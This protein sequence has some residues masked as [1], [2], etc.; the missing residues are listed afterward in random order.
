MTA[1]TVSTNT[2]FTVVQGDEHII[3]AGELAISNGDTVKLTTISAKGQVYD[4]GVLVPLN[5][6]FPSADI[7]SGLVKFRHMGI[8][9]TDTTIGVEAK[10]AAALSA[11][12]VVAITVGS[13]NDGYGLMLQPYGKAATM[14]ARFGNKQVAQAQ[15]V[16]WDGLFIGNSNVILLATGE[17][18]VGLQLNDESF[19]QQF[20]SAPARRISAGFQLSCVQTILK[21]LDENDLTTL[22]AS[23]A[24]YGP[25]LEGGPARSSLTAPDREKYRS[26]KTEYDFNPGAWQGILTDVQTALNA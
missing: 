13:D 15:K 8:G 1:P 19:L 10:L 7:A 14:A 25:A 21:Y 5:G 20:F 26:L 4:N 11:E 23:I 24:L 16:T 22:S 9:G 18:P 12:S 3:T 17:A 2:G 6:T